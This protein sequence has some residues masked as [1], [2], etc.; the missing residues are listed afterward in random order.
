MK[1][2]AINIEKSYANK[3]VL[4]DI[5]FSA[6][7][8]ETVKIEGESG[9][10]KTTLLRVMMGLET[11]DGGECR[12]EDN[13][14][15][16][17]SRINAVFQESRLLEEKNAIENVAVVFPHSEVKKIG[18]R[19]KL[20]QSIKEELLQLLPEDAMEKTPSMLSGGMQRRIEIVR[21]LMLPS[22]MVILDEPF[23]GLDEINIK[24]AVRYIEK[25]K[26]NR[27]LLYT[28]HTVSPLAS[29]K[30]VLL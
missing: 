17:K 23:S 21:A 3:K 18:G 6:L 13:G 16:Q 12:F 30:S 9:A 26:K 27:I 29:D 5:S 28:A 11:A 10:G 14:R 4:Q 1:F 7:S 19:E 15:K 24:K 8:G 22:D 2:T 25:R 20:Y